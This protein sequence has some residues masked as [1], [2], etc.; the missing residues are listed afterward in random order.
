MNETKCHKI[1]SG[2]T[3]K[4]CPQLLVHD[5]NMLDSTA[6]KY[7]GDIISKDGKNTL[8]IKSRTEKSMGIVS[9]IK[10]ILKELCL[11]QHHFTTAINLRESIF[12]SKI[13]LNVETWHEVTQDNIEQLECADRMLIK[14]ILEVPDSTP[15]AS[16]YLELG[17]IPIRFIIQA[18]RILYLH[19]IL[20]R[21]E[22]QMILKVLMAQKKKPSKG[23]WYGTALAE[24]DEFELN[25]TIEEFKNTKKRK[26][27]I[28]VKEAMKKVAF[29][30]LCIEKNTKSKSKLQ[31]LHYKELKIQNYFKTDKISSK[32]KINLFKARTRMLNVAH[33]FG[34]QIK[35]RLCK[36]E[37][38]NQNHLLEC[39]I[40]KIES[41]EILNNTG[42]KISD[43]YSND[44]EKQLSV[45]KLIDIA[46]R[47][48]DMIL[49]H[50]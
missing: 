34:Q 19:E 21:P 22:E 11:G 30:Y 26:I 42:A 35:C 49:N 38:D 39:I 12:L 41:Q 31:N 47:K 44:I 4:L 36:I 27:K 14:R 43:I 6:E 32:T 48:R 25:L 50:E 1:H 23:D 46:M 5:E 24:I 29:N 16:L 15:S 37:D 40:I 28:K 18:K 17:I 10:N 13:L 3:S 7:L 2:P 45:T 9:D 33:N 20:N 8:N